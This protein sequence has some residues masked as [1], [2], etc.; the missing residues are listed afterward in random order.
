MSPQDYTQ[1]FREVEWPILKA[2]PICGA[3][4]KLLGHGWYRRNALPTRETELVVMIHRLLCP[5]CR[6]TVSLLPSFLLPFFQ[7]TTRFVVKSLLGK[8]KSYR[9]LLRFHWRRFLETANGI[10]AFLRDRG[11]RDRLPEDRKE[12]AMKLLGSIENSGLEMFSMLF[13]KTNQ[14]GFMANSS[15][16]PKKP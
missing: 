2:C 15:Y 11:V 12:R 9:E 5:A 13:H 8:A 7:Y 3:H 1:R 6:K 16:L 4:A 14:R 10:L